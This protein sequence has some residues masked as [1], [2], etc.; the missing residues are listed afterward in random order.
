MTDSGRSRLALGTAQFGLAYGA[1]NAHG[2]VSAAEVGEILASAGSAGITMLD[3][4][5]AYGEAETVLGNL[6]AVTASFRIVTKTL[7]GRGGRIDREQAH[8]VAEALK[9]SLARLGR[10]SLDALLVHHGHNLLWPGGERLLDV[11]QSAKA[12]GTAA[13]IGVSV[14]DPEELEGIL[15]L[16]TPDVVQLP[17][18]LLDQRF[19]T[20]GLIA[21]LAGLGIEV[22][23][24]SLFLQGILLGRADALPARLGHA[25]PAVRK[26]DQF[27]TKHRLK[28]LEACLG[29][30]LAQPEIAS[31][32]V[33]V[34]SR[35][36]L[37]AILDATKSAPQ[38]F[39]RCNDLAC[40]DRSIINPSL[41]PAS[42]A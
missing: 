23:A 1:T 41:W 34:T 14:Y 11:V 2:R 7:G 24:R 32:V 29:F 40:T 27:V 35:E 36:E 15:A 18:N 16:F 33:G 19:L 10:R 38:P 39:P 25:V 6:G 8:D 42:T 9:R 17:F 3:T 12:S 37:A 26:F 22:H 21:R 13:R 20:S 28:R 5:P 30:G 4:A 31:L